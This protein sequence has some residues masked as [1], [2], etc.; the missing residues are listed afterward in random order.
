M[1]QHSRPVPSSGFGSPSGLMR[2]D[3]NALQVAVVRVDVS[4]VGKVPKKALE[5]PVTY[6]RYLWSANLDMTVLC[7]HFRLRRFR[8][9]RHKARHVHVGVK[10]N[11][12]TQ[13]LQMLGDST[14][15]SAARS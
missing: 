7:G 4:V 15:N 9:V 5:P 12:R 11:G 3:G 1:L 8:R 2:V 6:H 14:S 13:R 10:P